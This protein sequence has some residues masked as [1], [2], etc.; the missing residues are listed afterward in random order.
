M[1]QANVLNRLKS[2]EMKPQMDVGTQPKFVELAQS[3]ITIMLGGWANA[4]EY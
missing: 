1:K 3:L 4:F 2:C